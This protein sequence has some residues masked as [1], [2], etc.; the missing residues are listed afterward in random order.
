MRKII[1]KLGEADRIMQIVYCGQSEDVLPF[2]ASDI[3]TENILK[4]GD[5]SYFDWNLDSSYEVG[6]DQLQSDGSTDKLIELTKNYMRNN[7][8]VPLVRELWRKIMNSS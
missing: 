8:A 3:I 5:L 6:L 2:H 4:I 7:S 1:H